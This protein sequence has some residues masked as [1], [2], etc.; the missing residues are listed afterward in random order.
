MVKTILEPWLSMVFLTMAKPRI[1][2]SFS[3]PAVHPRRHGP[4]PA[5]HPPAPVV[6][7]WD[8]FVFF[9]TRGRPA[10]RRDVT[11]WLFTTMY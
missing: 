8:L 2:P 11:I 7:R 10:G 9:S 5:A 3:P 1:F 6:D 4:S